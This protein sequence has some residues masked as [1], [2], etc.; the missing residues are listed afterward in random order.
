MAAVAVE[1]AMNLDNPNGHL[2]PFFAQ[3]KSG[4]SCALV[5]LKLC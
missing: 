5:A 3:K 1:R 2:H 4:I